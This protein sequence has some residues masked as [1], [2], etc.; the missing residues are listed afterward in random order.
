MKGTSFE[1]K[2][3]LCDLKQVFHMP[4][5][6]GLKLFL[7]KHVLFHKEVNF[8]GHLVSEQGIS[9]DP[10]RQRQLY[11]VPISSII[12]RR[13]SFSGLCFYYQRFLKTSPL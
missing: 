5:I 4:K 6:T 2:K 12:K 9:T 3:H 11:H 8:V 1:K 7:K 10:K 13:H